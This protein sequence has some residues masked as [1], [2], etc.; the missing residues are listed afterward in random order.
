[1]SF[2]VLWVGY[3]YPEAILLAPR[4]QPGGPH[5]SEFLSNRFNGLPMPAKPWKRGQ[6]T[7]L[8]DRVFNPKGC[9]KVAGGRSKAETTGSDAK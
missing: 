7:C 8:I 3:D 2:T 4:L 1:M 5:R 9:Q 6:Y